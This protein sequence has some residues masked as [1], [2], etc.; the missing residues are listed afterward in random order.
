MDFR[1]I[2]ETT[3]DLKRKLH[4]KDLLIKPNAFTKI[5]SRSNCIDHYTDGRDLKSPWLI[6]PMDK[7]LSSKNVEFLSEKMNITYPRNQE[8]PEKITLKNPIF[9]SIGLNDKYYR[10][11][12]FLLI[13]VANGHMEQVLKLCYK[14]KKECPNTKLM[15][16]NI[17]N[18]EAYNA[19]C[20]A[21]LDYIRVGIGSGNVCTTTSNTGI[22]YPV[23]N[24][25][26]ECNAIK[27]IRKENNKFSTYIVADGG[28]SSYKD[29]IIAL[30]LGADYVM[31]GSLINKCIESSGDNYL[32]KYIKVPQKIA[33]L[34][35]K[36]FNLPIWKTY[37]G[38]STTEVQKKWKNKKLRASEGR[39]DKRKVEYKYL[40]F[41]YHLNAYL[42]SSMSYTDKKNLEH[43]IGNVKFTTYK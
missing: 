36:Q 30:G 27:K 20:E 41:V 33:E 1:R 31:M 15:I 6:A 16:G 29:A 21:G 37:R 34:L 10:D 7:V 11:D 18:S 40:D 35:F 28:I 39:K 14:I 42:R 23:A 24:L 25:I 3:L 32:F 5:V 13:D 4:Y 19:Y 12:E 2:T 17:A 26:A 8:I 38:M 22:H 43:F 9:K